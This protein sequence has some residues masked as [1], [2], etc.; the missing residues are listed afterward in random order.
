MFVLM[1]KVPPTADVEALREQVSAM[2]R[3]EVVA[4]LPLS[5]EMVSLGSGDIF[6]N[7]HPTHPLT[8]QLREVAQRIINL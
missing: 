7:R 1:N 4:L 8:Q 5:T 2:Y 6:C 3:T